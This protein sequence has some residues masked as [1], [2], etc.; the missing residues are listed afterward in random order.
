MRFAGIDIGAE[1]HV[2]AIVDQSGAVVLKATPIMEDATGY[3][4]LLELLGSASDCMVAMEATGHYWR[5]LFAALVTAGFKIALINPLRSIRFAEEEL[6]RTKTDAIDAL[7]I[8]RFAAQKRPEITQLPEPALQELRELVRLKERLVQEFGDRVRQLHRAVDLGFPE[9]T[10]HIRTLDSEL[11][12]AVLGRYPTAA[13]LRTVSV[14]RLARLCYDGSHNVGEELAR[15]LLEAAGQS[16]GAHHGEPYQ[17]QVRYACE[18]LDV[19]RRRLRSLDHDIERRLEQHEVGKLLTTIEGIGPQTAARI[20]AE[21]GDPARFHSA[22][23][24]ASYVGVIPR[25]HQSGKRK[26]SSSAKVP[27]GNARLRRALWMPAITAIHHN[28]W[29]QA[30]YQ[31]LRAA[32]KRPKVALVAIIRKLMTAVYSV[33]K[34]RR[35]FVLPSIF[36]PAA[37]GA[38]VPST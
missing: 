17:L 10:C 21:V 31:H 25:V 8:A 33:A 11:A 4:R 12:T 18:D 6:Q 38:V 28:P 1:R 20:I 7:G 30:Y 14:R 16:V 19:L 22:R 15:A 24:L 5:N 27:L 2:V 29:L 34:H 13:A 23:A 9:F 32:G 37:G 36:T 26:F 3:K 35:P